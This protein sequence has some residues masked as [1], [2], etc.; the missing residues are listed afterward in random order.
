MHP[1]VVVLAPRGFPFACLYPCPYSTWAVNVFSAA[2]WTRPTAS[3]KQL[4][5]CCQN[6]HGLF[7]VPILCYVSK[8]YEIKPVNTSGRDSTVKFMR[9]EPSF[10]T[11]E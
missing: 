4:S 5:M 7:T 11:N 8:P 10:M 3:A 6:T 9:T 2:V 1:G